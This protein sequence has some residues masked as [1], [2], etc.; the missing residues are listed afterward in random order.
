MVQVGTETRDVAIQAWDGTGFV[1]EDAERF[2]RR[3]EN[4]ET[5]AGDQLAEA[6]EA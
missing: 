1:S 4:W 6:P 5:A 2:V 3:G